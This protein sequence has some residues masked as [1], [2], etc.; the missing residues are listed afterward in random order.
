MLNI[1]IQKSFYEELLKSHYIQ[2]I[3]SK[4]HYR[5]IY[6]QPNTGRHGTRV[7][8]PNK[9]HIGSFAE[10]SER[11]EQLKIS[12]QNKIDTANQAEIYPDEIHQ[13]YLSS[14]YDK[15][16]AEAEQY[17]EDAIKPYKKYRINRETGKAVRG[18]K[19]NALNKFIID[20]DKDHFIE[21]RDHSELKHHIAMIPAL[22]GLI[23]K[24]IENK[25]GHRAIIIEG[26]KYETFEVTSRFKVCDRNGNVEVKGIS[27][28]F[29]SFLPVDHPDF[30][31]NNQVVIR[32]IFEIHDKENKIKKE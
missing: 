26:K 10:R 29:R 8:T 21:N 23:E 3:G 6:Y 17:Y 19:I 32:S 31:K 16:R 2:R 7:D 24:G 14:T 25:N 27:A 1:V 20:G 15:Y 22:P 18:V 30:K 13:L 28:V 9:E 5:Y 12:I 4:G 11:N